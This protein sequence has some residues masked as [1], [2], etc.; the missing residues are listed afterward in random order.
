MA[1]IGPVG[2]RRRR[3]DIRRFWRGDAGGLGALAT[4][5]AGSS[6]VFAGERTRSV[7][8]VA[9][10]DGMTLA[11]LV[12]YE[13]K[14][15][16]ANGEDN[17]DGHDENLSWNNGVEGPSDDAK[18]LD[19]RAGDVR[20]LLATLFASR[21][22][23]ML[24]AGDE[25]GRSQHGNNNAY[26]QDNETTW[27]DWTGR[28]RALEDFAAALS[29]LR[30]A[31]PALRDV[32]FLAGRA[33][34]GTVPDVEWLTET[35]APLDDAA[36]Q[37]RSRHRLV[38][39]LRDG[40]AEGGRLAVLVNGGRRASTF[41]LPRREG[42][43]WAAALEDGPDPA[44]AVP[45]RGVAFMPFHFGGVYQGQDLRSKYPAGADPIVLGEAANTATTY[46]YD[47]VTQMQETKT[48]LCRIQA[49]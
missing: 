30:R 9:A 37:D 3:D 43:R 8:F 2:Y 22:T 4:R 19:R 21:G 14:H 24:T 27:L 42:Y 34:D 32:R 49:A 28:D 26:A 20:A 39:I 12:A 44:A 41:V 45:G 17:R 48:T 6:D 15:N 38:M 7:N 5:L 18:I 1:G 16:E 46:G 11:D 36:W 40:N 31:T 47:S 23:I 13:R 35:G 25:F 33:D 29:A 10:H